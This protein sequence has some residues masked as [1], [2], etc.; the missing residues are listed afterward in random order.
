M[1]CV[2]LE[3]KFKECSK[4]C[5]AFRQELEEAEKLSGASIAWANLV[6]PAPLLASIVVV[7]IIGDW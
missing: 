7:L 5:L 1:S 2:I 3:R 6:S 4:H